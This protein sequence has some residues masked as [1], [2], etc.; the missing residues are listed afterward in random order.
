MTTSQIC[1]F[2][3]QK[4]LLST[5]DTCVFHFCALLCH[6]Q[7]NN[8]KWP[9]LS[10]EVGSSTHFLKV[11]LK[12]DVINTIWSDFRGR[13]LICG[14]C[15]KCRNVSQLIYFLEF[16]K[17]GGS[18]PQLALKPGSHLCNKYKHKHKHKKNPVGTGIKIINVNRSAQVQKKE[19]FLSLRFCSFHEWEPAWVKHKHDNLHA[20]L[21]LPGSFPTLL[22]LRIPL[23][24]VLIAQVRTKL[25][26]SWPTH[27]TLHAHT[28]SVAIFKALKTLNSMT[29][30][31]NLFPL[32]IKCG[33]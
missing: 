2:R 12:L 14:L 13:I 20:I 18:V 17:Q 8:T 3:G 33:T 29:V 26:E 10:R 6:R 19:I 15:Q 11:N 23:I 32:G 7:Q 1:I 30:W 21:N 25:K 28:T 27:F 24:L 5:S 16:S 31:R 4:Q 9:N 22:R